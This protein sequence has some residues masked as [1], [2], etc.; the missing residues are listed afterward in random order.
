NNLRLLLASRPEQDIQRVL[1]PITTH[2]LDLEEKAGSRK[3]DIS[4][5]IKAQMEEHHP[6]W[7]VSVREKVEKALT[8]GAN[9]MFLWVSLQMFHLL[10]C[11]TGD[12]ERQL[13]NL[14]ADV[15]GTYDRMIERLRV[16]VS[17]F[18]RSRR[19]LDSVAVQTSP[20]Y[21]LRASTA[22]AIAMVDL[23]WVANAGI[24]Q[25][26]DP[27][28]ARDVI[29]R[30][31]SSFLQIYG[32]SEVGFVHFTAQEYVQGLA[33]FNENEALATLFTAFTTAVVLKLVTP[34]DGRGGWSR[35]TGRVRE[36]DVQRLVSRIFDPPD[37]LLPQIQDGLG[38]IF[39]GSER[40]IAYEA[41][42]GRSSAELAA[43]FDS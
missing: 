13:K 37:A 8:R 10:T 43:V 14:P 9:G 3:G 36:V 32:D 35:L 2:L 7:S 27:F 28:D 40:A 5:F 29:R 22:A 39:A 1:E 26:P 17:S 12:I 42:T 34:W 4:S 20:I 25:P 41:E 33:D 31:G 11:E 6:D 16:D 24:P 21:S 19:L 15:K 30:R 38:N 23:D 18:H